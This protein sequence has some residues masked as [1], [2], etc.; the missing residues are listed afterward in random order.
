MFRPRLSARMSGMLLICFSAT[1]ATAVAAQAATNPAGGPPPPINVQA[2]L[3]SNATAQVSWTPPAWPIKQLGGYLVER[4][5]SQIAKLPTTGSGSPTT[6][7]DPRPQAGTDVYTVETYSTTGAHSAPSVGRQLSVSGSAAANAGNATTGIPPGSTNIKAPDFRQGNAP[8]AFELYGQ[9]AGQ[10]HETYGLF[11]GE[12]EG[13][14]LFPLTVMWYVTTEF[15]YLALTFLAWGMT[16]NFY[17]PLITVTT[18]FIQA[19]VHLPIFPLLVSVAI[20]GAGLGI[21][22]YALRNHL[23]AV[24]KNIGLMFVFLVAM[25]AFTQTTGPT[26]Q[27]AV[28]AP[29]QT[30]DYILGL[31]NKIEPLGLTGGNFGLEVQPTFNG[32]PFEQG[33]R[34]FQN[35]EWINDVYPAVCAINFGN[36]V[37]ATSTYVPNDGSL[38]NGWQH[39]TY[40][41]FY[42]KDVA[43]GGAQDSY[44]TSAVHSH[45]PSDVWDAFQGNNIPAHY[46]TAGLAMLV[47]WVRSLFIDLLAFAFALAEFSVAIALFKW[48]VIGSFGAIPQFRPFIVSWMARVPVITYIV[49][50]SLAATAIIALAFSDVGYRVMLQSSWAAMEMAQLVGAIAAMTI[51]TMVWRRQRATRAIHL[52]GLPAPGRSGGGAIGSA[53]TVAAAAIASGGTAAAAAAGGQMLGRGSRQPLDATTYQATVIQ[54]QRRVVIQRPKAAAL[55][56][57][58]TTGPRQLPSGSSGSNGSGSGGSGGASGT[59]PNA[60]PGQVIS[61]TDAPRPRPHRESR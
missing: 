27:F 38:P 6:Y 48:A 4:N 29:V 22:L 43:N 53:A 45:A 21:A 50:V 41:E 16:R 24:A 23:S 25:M 56:P 19:Y 31:V 32:D 58:I 54:P 36:V 47:I 2:V 35:K 59:P 57:A 55:G 12:I 11:G 10:I 52:D 17:A 7:T 3:E 37:W 34:Q 28:N 51:A 8:T 60:V 33:V 5:G 42:V 61:R 18:A 1:F 26:V 20:M 39:L 30:G 49:P 44:L 9:A 13:Y 15:A 14:E 46:F 40:C